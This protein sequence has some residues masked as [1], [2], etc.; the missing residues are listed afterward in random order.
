MVSFGR[1]R[2]F[3]G[4][5]GFKNWKMLLYLSRKGKLVDKLM[6][7]EDGKNVKLMWFLNYITQSRESLSDIEPSILY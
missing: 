5:G 7:Q 4:I 1:Y 2:H 3:R 6:I